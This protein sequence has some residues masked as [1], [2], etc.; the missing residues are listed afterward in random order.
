MTADLA[1]TACL[2]FGAVL[3]TSIGHAGASAYIAIMALFDVPV[4]TMRPTALALNVLVSSFTSFRFLRAGLFRWRTLWP[5]VLT[6]I[7]MAAIGGYIQLPGQ[8]YRP[9]VGII[10]FLAALRFLLPTNIKQS[11]DWHDPPVWA[12]LMCGAAIGLLSGLS[13]TGG[14]IFLSPLLMVFRWSEVRTASGVVA[15]FILCN[16]VSGLLGNWASLGSIAPQLPQ[17]AAAVMLGAVIG[18]TLGIR[19]LSTDKLLKALGLV[20]VIAGAKMIGVY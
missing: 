7:P 9:F 12:G 19:V 11:A 5:F 16:S 8:Y 1:L 6:A 14:G 18:T 15:V 3:Y 2:F 10:L 4:V 20:L 13:G 17:Y